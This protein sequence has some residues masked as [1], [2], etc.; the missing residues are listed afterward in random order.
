MLAYVHWP[1]SAF[2]EAQVLQLASQSQGMQSTPLRAHAQSSSV[3][4][5]PPTIFVHMAIA[6]S[7]E[8]QQRLDSTHVLS[9]LISLLTLVH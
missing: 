9:W 7:H 5:P 4:S 2:M 6:S 1:C 8:R 3:S